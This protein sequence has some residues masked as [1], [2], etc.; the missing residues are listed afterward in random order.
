[1]AARSP[2]VLVAM[3]ACLLALNGC[4]TSVKLGDLFQ[5]GAP[6]PRRA[7]KTC[8]RLPLPK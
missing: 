2:R 3:A 4:E 5:K 6:A 7:R 1:M 8:P